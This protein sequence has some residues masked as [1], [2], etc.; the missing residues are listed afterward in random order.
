M[1]IYLYPFGS[2][3]HPTVP[4]DVSYGNVSAYMA[5]SPGQYTVASGASAR[6]SRSKIGSGW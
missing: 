6:L 4:R 3:G 5:V 1:D 2:P